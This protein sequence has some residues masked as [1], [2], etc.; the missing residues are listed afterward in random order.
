V[1]VVDIAILTI[2]EEVLAGDTTNTNASWLAEQVTSRGS[3][4]R[5][6]LTIPDDK[7]LISETVEQWSRLFDAVIVTGGLGGTHDDVTLD[8]VGDVFDRDTEIDD[9]AL[10]EAK[11]HVKEYRNNHPEQFE[12]FDV[13]INYEG[14]ASVPEDSRVL[15]NPV[16]LTP[17]WILENVYAFPGVPSEVKAIFELVA[18]DFNGSLHSTVLLTDQP[19]GSMAEELS[20]LQTRFDVTVGSYPSTTGRN[21]IKV[22]GSDSRSVSEASEYLKQTLEIVEIVE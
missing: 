1:L 8:A 3:S 2:G 13:N 7:K 22:S 10:E 12:Q 14:W 11:A 4:V 5:R 19:E 17:G 21:Q 18:E 16:G 20:E 15:L 6:I 9:I